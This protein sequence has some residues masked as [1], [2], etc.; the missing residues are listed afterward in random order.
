MPQV[1]KNDKVAVT[2]VFFNP[3]TPTM[4]NRRLQN[5]ADSIADVTKS[6]WTETLIQNTHKPS[7]YPN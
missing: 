7:G 2:K 3:S 6:V 1:F 4:R 5:V